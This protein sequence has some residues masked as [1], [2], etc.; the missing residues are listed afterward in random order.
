MAWKLLSTY[1][2]QYLIAHK[3]LK[4]LKGRKARSEHI[5]KSRV[6]LCLHISM[7]LV[8]SWSNLYCRGQGFGRSRA[9]GEEKK[10]CALKLELEFPQTTYGLEPLDLHPLARL[11][12][13]QPAPTWKP[14]PSLS[15]ALCS[16]P[17]KS[18]L[19]AGAAGQGSAPSK[20]GPLVSLRGL[21]CTWPALSMSRGSPRPPT[22]VPNLNTSGASQK[23]F[24]VQLLFH[25]RQGF[26]NQ[27]KLETR[28]PKQVFI[29]CTSL[30]G[31]GKKITAYCQSDSSLR[32]VTSLT[33][34][35][36]TWAI[37]QQ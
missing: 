11:A 7:N 28:F 33:Q 21:A 10:G 30:T 19:S 29:Y 25:Y 18:Q 16:W 2:S 31:G 3:V 8:I 23:T 13:C 22:R 4:S 32:W 15:T 5:K 35:G 20:H 9:Q 12:G 14:R 24:A 37:W 1:P 27:S 26:L 6:T 17:N 34:P 36:G